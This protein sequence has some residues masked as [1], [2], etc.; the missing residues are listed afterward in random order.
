[1]KMEINVRFTDNEDN[2]VVKPV[3]VDVDV[4]DF[5]EFRGPNSFLEDFDVL[6]K[7]ALEARN[8]ASKIAIE[9]YLAEL[10]KKKRMTEQASKKSTK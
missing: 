2:E 9:E 8:S 10:S 1:M 5:D 3:T 4:P 7:A 6:E